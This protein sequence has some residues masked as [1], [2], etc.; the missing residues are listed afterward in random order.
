VNLI[1]SFE[2]AL[3]GAP[4]QVVALPHPWLTLL[5][6][7][8]EG[9]AALLIRVSLPPEQLVG[10][11]RGFTVKTERNN[12]EEYV[13]ITSTE[14]GC[15]RLFISLVE[16]VSIRT[17]EAKSE[18]EATGL[19]SKSIDEYR[20][21]LMRRSGRMTEDEIRG[22][23]A[24]LLL[25]KQLI[26]LGSNVTDVFQSWRG[27]FSADGIGVHD[28]TFGSGRGIEVKSTHQPPQEIRVSSVGQLRPSESQ[29]HLAV[30]PLEQVQPQT[31]TAI[32]FIGLV[33][34][35]QKLAVAAGK[36]ASEVWNDAISAMGLKLDDEF[37]SK[38][39][40][41]PG[42]WQAYAVDDGFPFIDEALI[43]KGISKVQ[44]SIVLSTITEFAIDPIGLFKR[45]IV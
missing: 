18:K 19:I 3:G 25:I 42:N 21:F 6:Q 26:D 24:E 7:N 11:G 31:S 15:S 37:Y 29:L 10:D 40:F 17:S 1:E 12:A 35:T 13:R 4:Y 34:E 28:F 22:F 43:P 16:Y 39:W 14:S 44:Y 5:A 32:S 8:M 23:F 9:H 41:I 38:W 30:L 33:E 2:I 45:G 27:P 20:Q 36:F